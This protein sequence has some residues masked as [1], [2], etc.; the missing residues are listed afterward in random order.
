[1]GLVSFV[2]EIQ[3]EPRLAKAAQRP[4]RQ[5]DVAAFSGGASVGFQHGR[6]LP[7]EP[8]PSGSEMG[9]AF[10]ATTANIPC[11]REEGGACGSGAELGPRRSAQ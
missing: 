3:A 2:K 10:Q 11:P 4:F 1:M 6:V 5:T 7:W 9:D 8:L